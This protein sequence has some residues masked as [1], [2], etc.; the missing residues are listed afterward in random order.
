MPEKQ[1]RAILPLG[2]FHVVERGCDYIK[3]GMSGSTTM[4]IHLNH[5]HLYDIKDGD[6]LTYYTEVL[7]SVPKAQN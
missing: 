6:L 1:M 2:K 7:L 3:V 4:T 5:M